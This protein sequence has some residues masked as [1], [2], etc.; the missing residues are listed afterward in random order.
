VE[1]AAEAALARCQ[2][3]PVGRLSKITTFSFHVT[4]VFT[5]GEGGALTLNDEA[6]EAFIPMIY[7]HGMDPQRLFPVSGYNYRLTNLAAGLLCA[8]ME[9]HE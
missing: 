3:H 5:C 2:G 9:R 1:D 7:S 4:K 8:Q 6:L